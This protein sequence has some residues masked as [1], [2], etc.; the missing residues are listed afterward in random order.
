[1]PRTMTSISAAASTVLA[2]DERRLGDRRDAGQGLGMGAIDLDIGLAVPDL[3]PH[4]LTPLPLQ[5]PRGRPKQLD[6]G[7]PDVAFDRFP[8]V[9][10]G[11]P[12]RDELAELR[13]GGHRDDAARAVDR[14][15]HVADDRCGRVEREQLAGLRRIPALE[16]DLAH[17]ARDRCVESGV[18]VQSAD[19]EREQCRRLDAFLDEPMRRTDE[20]R[21]ARA[22]RP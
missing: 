15:A 22:R 11:L 7:A 10:V 5:G 1:M 12:S 19:R 21:R 16:A 20:A 13:V 3:V 9:R 17:Q 18:L 2:T 4:P 14:M 6:R 8:P